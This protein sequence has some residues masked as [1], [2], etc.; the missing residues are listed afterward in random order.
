MRVKSLKSVAFLAVFMLLLGATVAG[1]AD[2]EG[3]LFFQEGKVQPH[4]MLR[5]GKQKGGL[6][7]FLKDLGSSGCSSSCC[8]ATANCDGADTQCSSSGCD[9]YCADGSHAGV[10]CDLA[11]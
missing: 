3:K 8:W 9:A 6:Q 11:E 10:T 1:A 7:S 4:H 5:V 2:R